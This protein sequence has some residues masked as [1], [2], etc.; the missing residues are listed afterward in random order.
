MKEEIFL[1][2]G[3]NH[4][5]A[6]RDI[7]D[8]RELAPEKF[9]SYTREDGLRNM[10]DHLCETSGFTP[11]VVFESADVEVI[12]NLVDAGVGIALLPAFWWSSGR[13]ERLARLRIATPEM[14]RSILLSWMK[15]RYLSPAAQHFR[16]FIT[17]YLK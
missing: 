3:R 5:W 16:Q 8:L 6:E 17:E 11:N 15:D 7:I 14:K 12:G 10:L 4:P 9:V 1:S 13:A 2:V